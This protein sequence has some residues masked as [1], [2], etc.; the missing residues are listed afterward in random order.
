MGTDSTWGV[1]PPTTHLQPQVPSVA[2][3]WRGVK[4]ET[5]ENDRWH[6]QPWHGSGERRGQD[7]DDMD[8][9][10]I[11]DAVDE[12]QYLASVMLESMGMEVLSTTDGKINVSFDLQDVG[13][14]IE[15]KL[16]ADETFVEDSTS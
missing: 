1:A 10:D 4:T 11:D 6:P 5:E 15:A 8:E 7:D 16:A 13:T 12:H 14:F 3:I 9:I 2:E